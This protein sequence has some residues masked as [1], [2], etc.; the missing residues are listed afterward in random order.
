[1]VMTLLALLNLGRIVAIL[2]DTRQTKNAILL[3][4]NADVLVHE[5][6]FC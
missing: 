6:T 4:Q 1:M 3:A 2:G 5:S